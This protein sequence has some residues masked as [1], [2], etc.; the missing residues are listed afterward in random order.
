MLLER[1]HEERMEQEET[2]IILEERNEEFKTRVVNLSVET[3]EEGVLD[4][5]ELKKIKLK[6]LLINK[7]HKIEKCQTRSIY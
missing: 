5:V 2:I 1:F 6:Q 3:S 4:S 7:L